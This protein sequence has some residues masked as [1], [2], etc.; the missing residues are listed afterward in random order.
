MGSTPDDQTVFDHREAKQRVTQTYSGPSSWERVQ[1][2]E[3]AM[4]WRTTHPEQGSH[5]AS[6][7]LELPRGRLR[8][9]FDGSKPNAQHAIDTAA[10][11]GWLDAAPG[12]RTFEG[13]SVLHAWILAGGSISTDNFVPSLAVG[14][15]DPDELAYAAF[16]AV[17][18]TY[19]SVNTD[20][21]KRAH[22]VRPKGHGRTHL[23]RFLHGVLGAPIG[24]KTQ[25]GAEPLQYLESVPYIT[26]L[27][28]CQTYISLRGVSIDLAQE[29]RTVRLG[30]KRSQEYR[31]ALARRFREVVGE[32]ARITVTQRAIILGMGELTMLDVVPS[33]PSTS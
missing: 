21:T 10:S 25:I 12:D 19:D 13:L 32:D 7:A 24:G 5:V 27:R 2:Y 4:R 33:L 14:A 29:A 31:E 28:W 26:L 9:W 6:R 1:E 23:G 15:E 3:D 20:S 16:D 30:E 11:H 22:E 17:G 18:M 8:A